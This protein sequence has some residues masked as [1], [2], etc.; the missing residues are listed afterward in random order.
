MRGNT[1]GRILLCSKQYNSQ[2]VTQWNALMTSQIPIP[3]INDI[4]HMIYVR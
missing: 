2:H 1:L 4:I 3:K